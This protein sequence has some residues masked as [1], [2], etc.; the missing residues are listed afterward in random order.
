MI[1]F[2]EVWDR[3]VPHL[4]HFPTAN[5]NVL[6]HEFHCLGDV[7]YLCFEANMSI[8]EMRGDLPF[9]EQDHESISKAELDARRMGEERVRRKNRINDLLSVCFPTQ[10]SWPA[11][12]SFGD[13]LD[14]LTIE[15]IKQAHFASLGE[16]EKMTQSLRL[17]VAVLREV[18][19]VME[20]VE[21]FGAPDLHVEQRTYVLR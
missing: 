18:A 15:H 5:K 6:E 8:L 1:S 10:S 20:Q 11:L 9:D 21:E 7:N 12:F 13:G 17:T 16:D 3:I 2:D 14:R 4:A 19:I